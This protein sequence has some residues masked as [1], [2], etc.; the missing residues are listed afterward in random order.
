M[1]IEIMDFNGYK[2]LRVKDD[3]KSDSDL[4]ALKAAVNSQLT[5]GAKNL[6][7]S[8]TPGSFFYSK[9]IAVIVQVL[10]LVKEVGG[11][12]SVVHPVAR[13]LKS[14]A[15]IGLDKLIELCPKEENIGHR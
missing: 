7:L 15:V 13:V 8:F 12:F 3:I 10:G 9:T 2:V 14:L 4:S 1:N 5:A 11:N 6:A